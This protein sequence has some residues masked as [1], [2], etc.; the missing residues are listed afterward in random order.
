MV[1]ASHS[2]KRPHNLTFVR[3]FDY[4]VLD[5]VELGLDGET[6][7]KMT[8]FKVRLAASIDKRMYRWAGTE[9]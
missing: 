4:Q 3:L 6:F 2:K 9:Y 5:M 8:D 7:R 1:F